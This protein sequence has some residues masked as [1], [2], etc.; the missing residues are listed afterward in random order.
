MNNL[1]RNYAIAPTFRSV[2]NKVE[3]VVVTDLTKAKVAWR[4]MLKL[5][6]IQAKQSDKS[7]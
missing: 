3:V 1:I 5:P 2:E 6:T 4:L 7:N